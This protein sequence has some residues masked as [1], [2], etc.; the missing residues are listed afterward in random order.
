M[1]AAGI[2]RRWAALGWATARPAAGSQVARRRLAAAATTPPG[3]SGGGGGGDGRPTSAGSADAIY[4]RRLADLRQWNAQGSGAY[5]HYT[6]PPSLVS[7]DELRRT[8]GPRLA[9]DEKMP[10]EAVAVT[11]ACTG[12]A[13]RRGP[14][15]S[16]AQPECR[17]SLP[18]LGFACR[19]DREPAVGVVQAHLLRPAP[20]RQEAPDR[21]LG[22]EHAATGG[23]P[24]APGPR[25]PRRS[26]QRLQCHAAA[27]VG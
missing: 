24:G 19:P 16:L 8:W 10:S 21:V 27:P 1:A 20:G 7:Y 13:G 5:P 14:V 18:R 15:G 23:G 25:R 3:G 9:N 12:G 2:V 22:H 6:P 4:A 11:G 17:S 26:V